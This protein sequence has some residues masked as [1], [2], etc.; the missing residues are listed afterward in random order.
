MKEYREGETRLSRQTYLENRIPKIKDIRSKQ[1]TVYG[2][3][4]SEAVMKM[5]EKKRET[6]KASKKR[7]KHRSC[8][9]MQLRE[10][11]KQERAQGGCLGTG[12]RRKT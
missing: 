11:V 10:E 12:S 9:A 8:N 7:K 4:T 5:T 1:E 6:A 3:E 2:R